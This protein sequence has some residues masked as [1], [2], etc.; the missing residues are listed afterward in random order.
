MPTIALVVDIV[1]SKKCT[2]SPP[3]APLVLLMDKSPNFTISFSSVAGGN[4]K[5]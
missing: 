2:A 4:R 3:M 1:P 5:N